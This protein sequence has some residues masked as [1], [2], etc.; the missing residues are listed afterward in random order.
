MDRFFDDGGVSLGLLKVTASLF[1]PCQGAVSAVTTNVLVW[2]SGFVDL[3]KLTLA[4]WPSRMETW[5]DICPGQYGLFLQHLAVH[6]ACLSI[7]SQTLAT[8]HLV[9]VMLKRLP[10]LKR[11][12]PNLSQC[13]GMGS[14]SLLACTA[15]VVAQE[16]CSFAE[17]PSTQ[18]ELIVSRLKLL[19]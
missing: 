16:P 6:L 8:C 2:S 3:I 4:T 1:L 9:S 11:A 18:S 7:C 14:G 10:R 19:V 5:L 17:N 12:Q 15:C 13:D